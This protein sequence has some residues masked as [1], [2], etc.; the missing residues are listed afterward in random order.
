MAVQ[1]V[2]RYSST[3][4]NSPNFST[5]LSVEASAR[6]V[7]ATVEMTSVKM[8]RESVARPGLTESMTLSNVSEAP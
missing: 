8:R 7:A 4:R 5:K 1:G 6:P 3:A 2:N